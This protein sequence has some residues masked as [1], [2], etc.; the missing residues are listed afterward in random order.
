MYILLYKDGHHYNF[1][2]IGN[3]NEV[4]NWHLDVES[5]FLDGFL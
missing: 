3:T 1:D 5:A 2:Y 4:E